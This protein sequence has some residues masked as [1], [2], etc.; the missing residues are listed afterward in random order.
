L[1]ARATE[2][3][4]RKTK[5]NKP[6]SSLFIKGMSSTFLKTERL[7]LVVNTF[8]LSTLG[9]KGRRI[10]ANL[11]TEQVPGQPRLQRNCL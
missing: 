7:L 3:L 2:K 10:F 5:T 9:G 4:S 11:S 8:I 6:G 1:T